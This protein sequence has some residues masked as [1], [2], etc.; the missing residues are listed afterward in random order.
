[1][2]KLL[3]VSGT[4]CLFILVAAGEGGSWLYEFSGEKCPGGGAHMCP[5]EGR[6]TPAWVGLNT[7]GTAYYRSNY[8]DAWWLI[9]QNTVVS[10][11]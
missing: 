9:E 4:W 7:N 2:K 1:M 11:W 5:T 6:A 8:T 3:A 10:N